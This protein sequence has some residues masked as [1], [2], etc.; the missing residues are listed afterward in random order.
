MNGLDE[1]RSA[2][3]DL[4]AVSD[5]IREVDGYRHFLAAPTFGDV[6]DAAREHPL[7]YVAAA[8]PGGVALVV[9][10]DEVRHVPLPRLTADAVQARV[11]RH[12]AAYVKFQ[13]NRSSGWKGWGLALD[14]TTRW[15][16]EEVMGD[17]LEAA[18]SASTLVLVSGG[19]LGLLPLHAAWV[20]DPARADGRRYVLDSVA[21]SY[22]P[23]ARSLHAA[24]HLA[25]RDA[26]RVLAVADPSPKPLEFAGAEASLVAAAF[27][28]S[29]V[30]DGTTVDAAKEANVE[31]VLTR[32]AQVDVA[33]FACH[34]FADLMNPLESRLDLA[35]GQSLRLR[36]LLDL[37]NPLQLRL[38]TLS[39]CE[40]SLPGTD[41]PDEVVSLPSGLLQAGVGGVVASM[42]DVP[43]RPTSTLM[44]AF[45]WFWR[46]K[47]EA[48][49]VALQQ[50]QNWA[51]KTTHPEK[52]EFLNA[53][54]DA[55]MFPGQAL[56]PLCRRLGDERDPRGDRTV[57]AWGA[58]SYVGA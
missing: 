36:D 45:Y 29:H 6:S 2:R 57:A 8:A 54:A 40:S 13:S 23:N 35:G 39:A 49:S 42:W 19:L 22:V 46:H 31:N 26:R 50:A 1:I 7:V 5:E 18:P 16:W 51:R 33:H 38:A 24:Q 12:R 3:R 44:A 21:I 56:E 9:H 53:A 34:G 25:T 48:P 15:L 37:K 47:G 30:L 32:L 17:V 14:D 58:F 4:D 43:D 41:L 52:V 55:G 27:D 11:E 28:E 20:E 10:G